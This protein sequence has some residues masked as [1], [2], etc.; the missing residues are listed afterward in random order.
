[1]TRSRTILSAIL[2][3]LAAE[4]SIC[5]RAQDAPAKP[6]NDPVK[7]KWLLNEWERTTDKLKT[8]DV[9]IYRIDKDQKWK[10]ETHYE[11][12]AIFKA[13]D[14]ASIDI[15]KLNLVPVKGPKNHVE[16]L[17]RVKD[18]VW[19]YFD[20]G[21]RIYIFPVAKEERPRI[22]DEAPY[23]FLFKVKAKEAEER[24]NWSFVGENAKYYAVKALPKHK[25]DQASFKAVWLYLD[26]QFLLPA[27][28]ML[29]SPDGT[30]TWQYILEQQWPNAPV[31]DQRFQGG[32]IPGWT[33]QKDLLDL[34][35][36]PK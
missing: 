10:H 15:W 25:K 35:R 27:R 34:L 7:M 22:L 26:K 5:V 33:V 20:D 13:P 1:M 6:I 14:L 31:D 9:R 23:P 16:R 8:L 29:V 24:Y 4:A 17:V 12:A 21:R 18:A 36:L 11:V 3:S 32:L 19:Q 2:V 30:R 28:I